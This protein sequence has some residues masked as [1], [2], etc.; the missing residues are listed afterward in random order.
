[1]GK[2]SFVE[3]TYPCDP[4]N[5]SSEKN[6]PCSEGFNTHLWAFRGDRWENVC[7]SFVF[8]VNLCM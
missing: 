1:M 2:C 8:R 5:R 4:L 7:W 3:K 6:K